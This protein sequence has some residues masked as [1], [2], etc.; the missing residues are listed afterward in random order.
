[1]D[2]QLKLED[3]TAER[4]QPTGIPPYI[5]LHKKLDKQQQSIYTLLS[6]L[7]QRMEQVLE[8][9]SVA[10]GNITRQ[11]LRDEIQSLLAEVGL[12]SITTNT[13][14]PSQLYA[15]QRHYHMGGGVICCQKIL[16]FRASTHLA[17]GCC[18]GSV[19]KDAATLL[20]TASRPMIDAKYP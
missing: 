3:G 16:R 14:T 10:A 15:P 2:L 5:E 12:R 19:T 7:E 20:I 4:M 9:K 18:G 17:R 6:I 1:M 11:M 13:K 8:R